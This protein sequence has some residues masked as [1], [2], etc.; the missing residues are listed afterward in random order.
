MHRAGVA[1]EDGS[2]YAGIRHTS[3]DTP[4][5]LIRDP[6]GFFGG[7]DCASFYHVSDVD[8]S[9]IDVPFGNYSCEFDPRSRPWYQAMKHNPKPSWEPGV[10]IDFGLGNLI[11]SASAPL[12]VNSNSSAAI[13]G[14]FIANCALSSISN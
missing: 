12:F 2:L 3:H 8:Y 6:Q 13:L 1:F 11:M 9:V 4:V 14:V 5:A 7:G 10:Y